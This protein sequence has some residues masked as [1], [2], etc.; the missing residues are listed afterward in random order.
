MSRPCSSRGGSSPHLLP[1][2]V[3]R[4]LAEKE[5]AADKIADLFLPWRWGGRQRDLHRTMGPGW[6]RAEHTQVRVKVSGSS[7]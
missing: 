7:P 2:E 6:G 5:G 3:S 1:E 4:L